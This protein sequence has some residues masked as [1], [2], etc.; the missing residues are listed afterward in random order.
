LE[1][2]GDHLLDIPLVRQ[3]G[4]VLVHIMIFLRKIIEIVRQF[5]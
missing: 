5:I 3:E 2:N 4:G 1:Q